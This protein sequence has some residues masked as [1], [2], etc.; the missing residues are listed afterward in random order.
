MGDNHVGQLGDGTL[1]NT[2]K[3]EQIVSSGVNAIAAGNSH[4]LFLKSDGSLWTMGYNGYG[5]LGDGTF[6][7]TNNR[8]EQIVSNGVIAIAGGA[9]HSLFLKSD[10]SFWD[11]GYNGTGQLGDGFGGNSPLPE[12][13]Y[14][15]P[16]PV[17]TNS[18]SSKTNLQFNATCQFGGTF[19]LVAGTNL[20]QP[21]IQ[22]TSVATNFINN[23][24]NNLFKA[25]LTNAVNSSA[26]QQFYI[27]RSQ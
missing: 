1:N 3:P 17:L 7:T 11:M 4:N 10:N 9:Y 22:W 25:T 16:Q 6:N 8:P 13:I 5:E 26:G 12:Q 27:L 15:S 23:R 18:I 20:I 21:L 14:P 2:N 24:T 19:Y